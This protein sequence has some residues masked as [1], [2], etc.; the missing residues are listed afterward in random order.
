MPPGGFRLAIINCWDLDAG[1]DLRDRLTLRFCSMGQS[2]VAR[3]RR[4]KRPVLA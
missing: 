1:F 2:R 3:G 4:S